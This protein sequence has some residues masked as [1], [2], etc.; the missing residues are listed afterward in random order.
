MTKRAIAYTSDIILGNTGEIIE[1]EFQRERI[2][3]YAK[4]NEIEIVAWFEDATYDENLFTRPKIKEMLTY[5][6]PYEL[7]LVERTWAIS[8]KWKEVRTLLRILEIKK[9]QMK[10]ATTLWDCVSQMTRNYYRPAYRK[11]ELPAAIEDGQRTEA[12]A[13]INLVETYGRSKRKN[14]DRYANIVVRPSHKK[15][16]VRRP[17]H[18]VF[19]KTS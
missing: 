19:Q 10:A 3:A 6:E 17:R 5:T 4:E 11:A 16:A 12:P 14:K 9:V 1:R 15:N 13:A 8:R 7:V 18:L 2:E